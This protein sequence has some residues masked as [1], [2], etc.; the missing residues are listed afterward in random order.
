V[1][2][3]PFRDDELTVL[4]VLRRLAAPRR[5]ILKDVLQNLKGASQSDVGVMTTSPQPDGTQKCPT[6]NP[7]RGKLEKA[8]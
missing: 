8:A 7:P 6:K 2:N 3:R 1:K 4:L 5:S